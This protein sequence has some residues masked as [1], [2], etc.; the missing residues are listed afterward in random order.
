MLV[1][2]DIVQYQAYSKFP[3]LLLMIF[4]AQLH[5]YYHDLYNT[6]INELLGGFKIQF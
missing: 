4:D 2:M 5:H 6:K 3:V 1:Q